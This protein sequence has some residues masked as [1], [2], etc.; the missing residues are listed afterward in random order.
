MFGR[1][2][3]AIPD[4]TRKDRAPSRASAAVTS[5]GSGMT[6]TSARAAAAIWTAAAPGSLT[7][8][9]PA[10]VTSATTLLFESM[11]SSSEPRLRSLPTK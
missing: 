8:G 5:L 1:R 4:A 10:S 9:V 3:S 2:D 11:A 7:T 6:V